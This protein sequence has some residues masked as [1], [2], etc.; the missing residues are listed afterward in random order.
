MRIGVRI[1]ENEQQFPLALEEALL[2]GLAVF[3]EQVV[4]AV[5]LRER[6]AGAGVEAQHFQHCRG[7]L[8][9]AQS[10]A[11]GRGVQHA[12]DEQGAGDFGVVQGGALA[13]QQLGEAQVF[14]GLQAE[15]LGA[16]RAGGVVLQAVEIDLGE[17]AVVGAGGGLQAPLAEAVEEVLGGLMDGGVD[18]QQGRL[19]MEQVTGEGSHLAP[20][21][22][23]DR[24]GG[25]EVEEGFLADGGA[26]AA[27]FDETDAMRGLAG[28]GVGFGSAEE[29]ERESVAG[30]DLKAQV[31]Q[32]KQTS[33]LA[34][35]TG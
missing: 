29:H 5:Q 12:G 23:G 6:E 11:F 16:H 28:F 8:Q 10:L 25:A 15:A 26:V 24:V 33:A 14:E 19:A 3:P 35:Q 21:M 7:A 4:G 13:Q 30:G 32:A 18:R 17:A 20:E 27:G 34:L 31:E 22:L 2:E 9:P 1:R